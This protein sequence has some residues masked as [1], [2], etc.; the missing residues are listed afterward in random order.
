V[1]KNKTI[2]F[3]IF[4]IQFSLDKS[5]YFPLLFKVWLV[6]AIVLLAGVLLFNY[7]MTAADIPGGLISGLLVTY[8]IHL[9][10]N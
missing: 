7:K 8:L 6:M 5:S 9:F 1:K 2:H 10:Q 3:K 4:G